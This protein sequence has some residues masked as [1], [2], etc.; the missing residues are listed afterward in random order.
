[1]KKLVLLLPFLLF[2]C[3]GLSQTIGTIKTEDYKADF[4]KKQSLD[5]VSDYNGDI[6]IPI[7]ILKIGINDEVYEMY[8]ELKD[9]RVGLGVA[10]IVLEYLESTD[11]FKFTEDKS[12]IKN[13]M[14]AQDKASDK[15]I[16]S[17]KIEVK[18]NVILANYFVYI[19]VY[20]F[21]VSEDEV[22]KG[23][24]GAKITQTTRL[25]LQIRFVDAQTGE[26]ITGSGLG[27][28]NTVKT[29]SLLDDVDEIKFNQSTIGI[30]TKKSLETASS[31]VV[32]K[33]IKKGV[34]KE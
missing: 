30:S 20:D 18:G 17:N 9:K 16:S 23:S 21:S 8:P 5:V 25:G 10:N 19:E 28:S 15:G 22:I 26:V 34:F 33:L 29:S 6:V 3:I 7:Q 24:E 14:I 12:E 11:R 31:R 2:S 13:K 27:E 4:E 1:M 32:S